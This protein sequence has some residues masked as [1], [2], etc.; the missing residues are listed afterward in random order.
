M[1][2]WTCEP[3]LGETLP[4]LGL[5]ADLLIVHARVQA[6]ERFGRQSANGVRAAAGASDVKTGCAMD[7]RK[8]VNAEFARQGRAFAEA[9]VLQTPELTLQIADALEHLATGQILDAACGPGV[10]TPVLSQR[11][12]FVV[13][14]DATAEVLR[15]G[16]ERHDQITNAAFVQ[17]LVDRLPFAAACFDAIVLRLALHHFER[18][19]EALKEVRRL[20]R[21]HG[22]VVVLDIL[23]SRD[24]GTAELHNAIERLRD[25]SHASFVSLETLR[26]MVCE[27]GFSLAQER[28]WQT[29]R[30]FS[31]W[32]R[33]IAEPR[34]MASL[35]VILHRLAQAGIHA[36]IDLREEHGVL[37]FDYCFA[38]L[39]LA[40]A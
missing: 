26:E 17:G 2:Y 8:I 20:I 15:I 7:H 25:P 27:A 24:A 37:R 28:S 32:A 14:V 23:T 35:E 10:L 11:A 29:A 38:L 13:G 4:I 18:P 1:I 5:S 30:D 34:R 36:G 31:E 19:V 40:A 3:S 21:P 22:R 6:L 39:V 16:R 33:I 9:P 12:R